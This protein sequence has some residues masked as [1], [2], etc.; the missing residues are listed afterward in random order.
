MA[1]TI[2]GG[3]RA[4]KPKK[5]KKGNLNLSVYNKRERESMNTNFSAHIFFSCLFF[6][7]H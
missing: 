5:K 3:K 1:T 7:C 4:I 2:Q 6:F